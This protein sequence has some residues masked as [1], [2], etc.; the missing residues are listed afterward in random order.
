MKNVLIISEGKIKARRVRMLFGMTLILALLIFGQ[1]VSAQKEQDV[2]AQPFKINGKE[3]KN[4][5]M[6]KY[7]LRKHDVSSSLQQ[8]PNGP[9]GK[10][11]LR[12][13]IV[14]QNIANAKRMKNREDR[15]RAIAGVFLKEEAS[16]L[17]ITNMDE[18]REMS[19]DTF[20]SPYNNLT[21]TNIRYQRYI[22]DLEL[23]YAYIG[24]TIEH[25][26]NI[27]SVSAELVPTPPELY[28]AVKEKILTE[29]EIL[30]IVKQDLES[31]GIDPK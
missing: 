16:L 8:T 29:G 20:T 4:Y 6:E 3:V 11:H 9:S 17:G 28:E 15:A 22:N 1:T 24:I 23:E 14:P 2:I 30:K 31:A 10:L 7:K 12:G 5:L 19:I 26:G 18:I 21:T 25:D 27:R 13:D